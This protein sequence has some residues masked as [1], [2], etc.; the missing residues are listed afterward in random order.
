MREGPSAATKAPVEVA[1]ATDK[2]TKAMEE[3]Q[4]G[5]SVRNDSSGPNECEGGQLSCWADAH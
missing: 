2:P 1:A 5:K 4:L 3:A